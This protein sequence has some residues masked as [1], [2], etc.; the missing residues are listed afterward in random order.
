MLH[1]KT[2]YGPVRNHILKELIDE[3]KVLQEIII[4]STMRKGV[5]ESLLK[6]LSLQA[7]D[8]EVGS[9]D[10][11]VTNSDDVSFSLS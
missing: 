10:M 9:E 2:M 8:E 7:A 1:V 4:T 5:C 3:A 11:Y 6:M